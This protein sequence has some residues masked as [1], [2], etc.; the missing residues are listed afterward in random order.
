MIPPPPSAS[1]RA[2]GFVITSTFSTA[3]AGNNFSASATFI[4][5][6]PEGFPS[7][8]I[9]TF[10]FPRSAT[11]PSVSTV[12][13]GTLSKTSLTVPP[14]TIISLPTLYTLLSNL[15]STVDF[16]AIITTSCNCE[17][18]ASNEKAPKKVFSVYFF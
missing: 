17:I 9:F 12:T 11:F 14:L 18:S 15:I 8:N 2:D 6:K 7:I 13:E 16:S 5:A 1:Y 4:P 3:S 10:S